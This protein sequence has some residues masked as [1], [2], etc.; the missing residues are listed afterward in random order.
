MPTSCV[1]ICVATLH[2]CVEMCIWFVCRAVF[3]HLGAVQV[4]RQEGD[5]GEISRFTGG[6]RERW[7]G[8]GEEKAAS[9]L[10]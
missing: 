7:I 8:T 6:Q 9:P 1:F 10:I 2:K 4:N 3:E 5:V